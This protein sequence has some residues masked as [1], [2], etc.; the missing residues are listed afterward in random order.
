[1]KTEV[2]GDENRLCHDLV[3]TSGGGCCWKVLNGGG[4]KE[5]ATERRG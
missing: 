4:G 5:R 2:V 1:M 3:T